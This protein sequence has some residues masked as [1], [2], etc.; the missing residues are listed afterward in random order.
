MQSIIVC[1]TACGALSKIYISDFAKADNVKDEAIA[2]PYIKPTNA[3][4]CGIQLLYNDYYAFRQPQKTLG[5]FHPLRKT[6]AGI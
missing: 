2:L 5:S 4:H 3:F 1:C 6:H